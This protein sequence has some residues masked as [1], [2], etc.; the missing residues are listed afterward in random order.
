MSTLSLE[1]MF[2]EDTE[3]GKSQHGSTR[4]M[5]ITHRVLG[6]EGKISRD[7]VTHVAWTTGLFLRWLKMGS[8][9]I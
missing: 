5:T 7:W 1:R 4:R 6:V 3:R 2:N 8:L 9:K